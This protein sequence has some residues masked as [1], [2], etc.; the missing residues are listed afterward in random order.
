MI[1]HLFLSHLMITKCHLGDIKFAIENGEQAVFVHT[2]TVSQYQQDVTYKDILS[3]GDQT[4]G[5]A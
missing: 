3:Y 1:S 5:T 2:T 4:L